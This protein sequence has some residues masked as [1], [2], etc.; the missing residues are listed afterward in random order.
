MRTF[1]LALAPVVILTT[2]AC[3]ATRNDLRIVH[4]DLQAMRAERIAADSAVQQMVQ[5]V[6]QDLARVSDALAVLADSSRANGANLNRLRNDA[7]EDLQAIRQQL[8]MIQELT[9]QSQRRIQELRAEME[10]RAAE[11]AV[12][13]PLPPADSLRQGPRPGADTTRRPPSTAASTPAAAPA[14]GPAQLYQMGQD[15]LRRG[16]ISAARAVFAQLLDR[17][18]DSDLAPQALYGVAETWADEGNGRAADSVYALVVER[19]PRSDQAPNALYKR[20]SA[21]R[22]TGQTQQANALYRQIVAQ[23]PRSD[24]ALLAQEYLRGRP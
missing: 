15:Q 10:Q 14:P 17:Y 24:A 22:A 23:Y 11:L 13:A 12:P 2:G 20:A 18:P 6:S 5:Q 16:S 8:I 21:A 1:R 4:G 7:R 3:F 19:Y 9:G